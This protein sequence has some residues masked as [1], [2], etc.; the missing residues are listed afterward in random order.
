ML[1]IKLAF[2]N[3]VG[4]GLRTWLNVFVLS[5]AFVA[6]LWIQGLINGQAKQIMNLMIDTELGGGQFWHKDYEPFDPLTLEDSH[7]PVPVV[8]KDLISSKRATPILI[9][10]GA[11]YPDGRVQAALLKG[12]DPDQVIL[13]IPADILKKDSPI[14]IPALIGTRMAKQTKLMLG[15]YVTIRWRDIHGTFDAADIQIA[16]VMNTNSPAIDMGQIWIPLDRMRAMMQ[17]PDEATL[18][19]LEKDVQSVPGGS[20]EWIYRGLDFLLKDIVEIMKTK[21]ASSSILYALLMAMALLAIFDTQVLSIFRRRKEMGTL[22]ALGMTRGGVIKLFTLEGALH[23]ILALIIGAVYGIPLLY[24]TAVK[25]LPLPTDAIDQ[26]G[27]AMPSVLYPSYS[28]WLIGGTTFLVFITVTV[29]SFLPTRKIA[30][31]KPTD[32]LRGKLS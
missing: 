27:I 6:I 25:G 21:T 29:V 8:L 10:S 11:I 17:A 5:F 32:A 16:R 1:T 3:I 7:G 4:A 15:D 23:G 18:I 13:D 22:M 19:V 14:T 24:L 31:L 2:R 20:E 12:I 9:T 26:M 30:K 28:L